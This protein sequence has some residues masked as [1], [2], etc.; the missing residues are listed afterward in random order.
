L[1]FSMFFAPGLDF[2]ACNTGSNPVGGTVKPTS[3]RCHDHPSVRQVTSLPLTAGEKML[4]DI[5]FPLESIVKR[6]FNFA[7]STGWTSLA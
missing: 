7:V 2:Q 3:T 5:D 1:L 6:R 4:S